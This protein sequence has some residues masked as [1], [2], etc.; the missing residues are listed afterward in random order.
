MG[1]K[2]Q[3]SR[4]E[5]LKRLG[6]YEI[7]F[8]S[9]E[10]FFDPMRLKILVLPKKEANP[11]GKNPDYFFVKGLDYIGLKDYESALKCF[12]KGITD[13]GTH[14]LCRFNLGYTLFKVGHFQAAVK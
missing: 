5:Q 4:F 7:D 2:K 9:I 12:S 14:L 8:A 13:K 1:N 10:E 3:I 11:F 6:E